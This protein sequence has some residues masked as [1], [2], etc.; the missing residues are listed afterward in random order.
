MFMHILNSHIKF[1]ELRDRES[2]TLPISSTSLTSIFFGRIESCISCIILHFKWHPLRFLKPSIETCKETSMD[3]D[4]N[5]NMSKWNHTMSWIVT[6]WP[7]RWWS[8]MSFIDACTCFISLT[9]DWMR[10]SL[11]SGSYTVKFHAWTEKLGV[12]T[13]RSRVRTFL[14]LLASGLYA[15]RL[16]C[17]KRVGSTRARTLESH[18]HWC[19]HDTKHGEAYMTWI[20]WHEHRLLFV[21]V[22]LTESKDSCNLVSGS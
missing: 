5:M 11:A 8:K 21:H 20:V 18:S 15:I 19:H 1:K 2:V 17:C 14:S 12:D 6:S 7:R 9:K 22:P 16:C 13:E 3:M 10:A 4:M